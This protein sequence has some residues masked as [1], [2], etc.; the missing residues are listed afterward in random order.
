MP[1]TD[2]NIIR[3]KL[4]RRRWTD[5]DLRAI[6]WAL[7]VKDL[8]GFRV[9]AQA[10]GIEQSRLSRRIQTLE[11]DLGLA[12]FD[13]D[14]RGARPSAIG[15]ELLENL[16]RSGRQIE[17]SIEAAR[18]AATPSARWRIAVCDEAVGTPAH[19]AI[20]DEAGLQGGA[21]SWKHMSPKEARLAFRD[22]RIDAFIGADDGKSDHH[23]DQVVVG[24]IGIAIAE[25]PSSAEANVVR[26]STDIWDVLDEETRQEI[27]RR[28]GGVEPVDAAS[29]VL[30]KSLLAQRGAVVCLEDDC[31][32][33]RR[34][35][36]VRP[37]DDLDIK[38]QFMWRPAFAQQAA[39]MVQAFVAATVEA[40]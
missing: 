34:R 27:C 6:E 15:L 2:T 5:L 11:L 38:I 30:L 23:C 40:A 37:L 10:L 25:S 18:I 21:L 7:N 1:K 29:S 39:S 13:R 3:P 19:R 8:G 26:C 14:R 9:A 33:W 4:R 36:G 28:V 17:A 20:V 32:A 12:L 16:L 31:E 22:G 35:F 24:S